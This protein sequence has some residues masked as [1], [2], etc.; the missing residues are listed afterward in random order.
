[1]DNIQEIYI[2]DLQTG[3]STIENYKAEVSLHSIHII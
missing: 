1:M 2:G 3:A